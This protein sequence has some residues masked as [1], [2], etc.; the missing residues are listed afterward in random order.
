MPSRK[1]PQEA[2]PVRPLDLVAAVAELS[3]G[4]ADMIRAVLSPREQAELDA[5]L[6]I[7]ARKRGR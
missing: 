1:R 2:T 3:D 6:A 5:A 7:A 4:E